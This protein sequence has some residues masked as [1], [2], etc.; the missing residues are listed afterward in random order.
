MKALT[1]IEHGKFALQEKAKP[2]L[3]SV[4]DA[5]VRVTWEASAPVICILSMARYL[6]LCRELPWDMKWLV[7]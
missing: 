5:I 2:Q 7:W 1:Y 4:R 6:V 3:V